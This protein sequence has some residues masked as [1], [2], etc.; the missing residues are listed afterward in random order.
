MFTVASLLCGLAQ[1]QVLLI[2][3]GSFTA[4]AVR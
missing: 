1:S 4:S 2:G 3:R